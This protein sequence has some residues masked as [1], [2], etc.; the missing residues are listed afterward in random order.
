MLS[1]AIL[2]SGRGSNMENIL[3]AVK[4]NKIPI[5]PVI[6]ISNK[7][8]ARG[9]AIAQKIGIR[10]EIID[11]NGFKG[12]NWEYDSKLVSVLEKHG[13]T[14]QNGLIC[15]AGF[16]RIMSPEFIR[17]YKGR[18]MNIHPAILPAFPGLHSQRQ[19]LE[20]G[21]KYSGCTVHFVDEGVDTGP[22]ILQSVVKIK[23]NDTE[24]S[25]SKKILKQEHKIYPKAVKL[26]A[27][28]KIKIVGRKT[29]IS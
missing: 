16:M 14:P 17:H 12:G 24:E 21:V 13:V 27:K 25:I 19:A 23:D 5:K 22:I 26:F 2:I 9:L 10:T 15:L 7:P 1:L 8:D 11:S 29:V 3:K 20:Y 28:G 18:I 4:K 6:V